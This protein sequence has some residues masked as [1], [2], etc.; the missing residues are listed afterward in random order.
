MSDRDNILRKVQALLA[1]A[2]STPFEAEA[3]S[4]RQKANELMDKHRLEQWELAQAQQGRATSSLKPVRKDIDT[5][6]YYGT[7]S[8]AFQNALW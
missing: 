4:F 1:K 8:Y 2:M 7:G 3:D 5:S 6:W